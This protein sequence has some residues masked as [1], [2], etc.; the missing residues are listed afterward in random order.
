MSAQQIIAKVLAQKKLIIKLFWLAFLILILGLI[1]S[2]FLPQFASKWRLLGRKAGDLSVIFLSLSLLPGIIKRMALKGQISK[3]TQ[4]IQV[5]LMTFRRQTGQAMYL[6]ALSHYIWLKIFP[7][8][9]Y[10]ANP[11]AINTFQLLGSIAL[12]L[13]LPLFI[14]SNDL[15][16]K[17]LKKRW[18]ALHKLT[19]TIAVLVLLHLS[20]LGRLEGA[21]IV[22]ALILILEILSWLKT[23]TK[24]NALHS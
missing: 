22:V 14:T 4:P 11:L 19:Y 17:L 12:I 16:L 21:T 20:L 7:K 9:A 10:Q 1:S 15:S 5:I 18:G 8:F 3:L 13:T 6:L 2:Y 23:L 24:P